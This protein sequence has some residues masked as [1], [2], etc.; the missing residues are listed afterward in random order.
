M[1]A[2]SQQLVIRGQYLILSFKTSLMHQSWGHCI[3]AII[4]CYN[5]IARY[6]VI[7]DS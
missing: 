3:L 2:T 4:T 5:I 7:I 1:K 6:W